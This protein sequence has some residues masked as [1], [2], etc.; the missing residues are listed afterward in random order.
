MMIYKRKSS[1]EKYKSLEYTTTS[2]MLVFPEVLHVRIRLRFNAERLVSRS[3][4][5]CQT[6][7]EI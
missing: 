4:D 7:K 1:D 6:F 2:Q 3:L 5:F